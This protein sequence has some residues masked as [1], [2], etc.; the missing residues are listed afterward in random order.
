MIY[1]H[2]VDKELEKMMK[3]LEPK[4]SGSLVGLDEEPSHEGAISRR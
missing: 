1:T 3:E 2:V 4:T